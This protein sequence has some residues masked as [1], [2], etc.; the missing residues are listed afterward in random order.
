MRRLVQ[1]RDACEGETYGAERVQEPLIR[2]S[3]QK[4]RR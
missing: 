2:Y 1:G 4:A 3:P